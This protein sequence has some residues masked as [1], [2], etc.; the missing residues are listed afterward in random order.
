MLT[1]GLDNTSEGSLP[2]VNSALPADDVG[3]RP[4]LND[5]GAVTG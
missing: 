4:K 1:G 3:G 2:K 5:D